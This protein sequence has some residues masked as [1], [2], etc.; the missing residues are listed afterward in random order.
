[1][2]HPGRTR[3]AFLVRDLEQ[4]IEGL[5]SRGLDVPEPFDT[6]LG[7]RGVQLEDPDGNVVVIEAP[8]GRSPEWL[9]NQ[10]K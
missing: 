2:H 4:T 10:A 7:M 9:R 3:V 1:M 5:K 6:H 8:T